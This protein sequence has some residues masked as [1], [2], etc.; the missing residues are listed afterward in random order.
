MNS[1]V[2]NIAELESTEVEPASMASDVAAVSEPPLHASVLELIQPI[3]SNG[4]GEDPRYSDQFNQIKQEIDRLSDANFDLALKLSREVLV[5][6]GK[7]LRVAGYLI[8]STLYC[9]GVAVL[10]EAITV[11]RMIMDKL[12][13]GC[14]PLKVS[15]RIQAYAWLNSDR[16]DTFIQ[17]QNGEEASLADLQRL[18][19]EI[20]LLNKVARER[21]GDEA[22]QWTRINAWVDN[23]LKDK[24]AKKSTQDQEQQAQAQSIAQTQNSQSDALRMA[25]ASDG[26]LTESRAE[27]QIGK[28]VTFY[29]ERGERAQSI[30]LS[31]AIRWGGLSTPPNEAGV[32]RIP[33]FRASAM[34][35][36]AILQS[37]GAAAEEVFVVCENLLMEP[38]GQWNMDLQH[39]VHKTLTGLNDT[40]SLHILE[41]ELKSLQKRCS[42]LTELCYDGRV[43]FANE[44]TKE[45]LN[46]MATD[47]TA[48]NAGGKSEIIAESELKEI[49]I[50]ASKACAG[51]N[52]VA[53]LAVLKELPDAYGR[54]KFIKRIEEARL[55]IKTRHTDMAHPML[56][57]LDNE[58]G[59][60][61]LADWEPQLAITVWQLQLKLI[62][63]ELPKANTTQQHELKD[64]LK[65]IN[66]A[67]CMADLFEAART[68]RPSSD[69]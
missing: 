17:Q 19:G 20:D 6:E 7:D 26:P 12:W 24:L 52:L 8:L 50:N 60:Y 69:K 42:G 51:G 16:M 35:E 33:A 5:S 2:E 21:L 22:P 31:R 14:Y 25:A 48:E 38:G 32:T 56:A 11:Y 3:G 9:K 58:I 10:P 30:A 45:W 23:Y 54:Q 49:T 1:A 47:P 64:R 36:L 13:D 40:A 4:T 66:A 62:A 63:L 53:G 27:Q 61:N 29:R 68:N 41:A 15:A 18:R 43:P 39:I 65:Q 34:N 67:I 46:G 59:K 37:S 44:A 28:I 55:C 57:A